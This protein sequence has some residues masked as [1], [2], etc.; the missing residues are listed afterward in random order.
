MRTRKTL[1]RLFQTCQDEK[2]T[3]RPFIREIR[4]DSFWSTI[5]IAI[6]NIIINHHCHHQHN[7]QCQH[8]YQCQDNQHYH[9]KVQ[10]CTSAS[11]TS[12]IS[13]GKAV[14]FAA[15]AAGVSFVSQN[16]TLTMGLI[17]EVLTLVLNVNNNINNNNNN[18]NNL[19]INALDS[20]NVVANFNTNNANQVKYNSSF[21]QLVK[22]RWTSWHFFLLFPLLLFRQLLKTTSC[23]SQVN[24]MP[25]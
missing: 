23:Q 25:I 9:D 17:F 11:S 22:T 8:N 6:I 15:F 5:T 3:F 1:T 10:S 21:S 12:I 16:S 4:F 20:S 19:N 2:G 7:H 18:N 14:D 13:G 24:I